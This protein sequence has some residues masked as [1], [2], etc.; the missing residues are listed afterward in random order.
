MTEHNFTG[1]TNCEA[2]NGRGFVMAQQTFPYTF[3]KCATCAGLG[4]K[5]VELRTLP[6]PV[7]PE[8]VKPP[9]TAYHP[10]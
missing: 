4:Q 8:K 5:Y 6:V 2:C 3:A 9:I 7:E 1:F 10:S